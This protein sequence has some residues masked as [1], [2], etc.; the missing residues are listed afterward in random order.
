MSFEL[1]SEKE[2][3]EMLLKLDEDYLLGRITKR[4]YDE[5]KAKVEA[6]LQLVKLDE[7]MEKGEISR[8][9]YE[10]ERAKLVELARGVMTIRESVGER[11][12][13]VLPPKPEIKA[14]ESPAPPERPEIAAPGVGAIPGPEVVRPIQKVSEEKVAVE[15]GAEV[16]E[17]LRQLDSL[18]DKRKRLRELFKRGDI[19]DETFVS[20]FL[21]YKKR[22]E[23]V[24]RRLKGMRRDI[25]R[26]M[27]EAL[28]ELEK[29][30]D[31]LEFL[32]ARAFLGEIDQAE[33]ESKRAEILRRKGELKSELSTLEKAISALRKSTGS[34]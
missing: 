2:L 26:R 20:I 1:P 12:E 34:A 19:S 33:F 10:R 31:E 22:Y 13:A 6:A 21:D 5:K 27:A 16:D 30:E 29:L 18:E 24:I 3:R 23:E 9:E 14:A 7:K 17:L 15:L 25:E 4:E 32:K 28:E 8:E 11:G